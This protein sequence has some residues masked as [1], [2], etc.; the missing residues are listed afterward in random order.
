MGKIINL[1]R[2]RHFDIEQIPENLE[3][4]I[5]QDFREFT[6]G[7]AREYTF[8]DKLYYI[9]LMAEILHGEPGS[10]S[11]ANRLCIDMFKYN[12]EETNHFTDPDEFLDSGFLEACVD[13]GKKSQ[14]LYSHHFGRSMH[15]NEEI[16]R[17]MVRVITTVM[18]WD[19][20]KPQ[21]NDKYISREDLARWLKERS[22]EFDLEDV[23]PVGWTL[24]G[25]INELDQAPFKEIPN[26]AG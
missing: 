1:P 22:K 7:T 21:K 12:L 13:A 20:E 14:Q 26:D 19:P 9:D 17:V 18:L 11:S 16:M 6:A 10:A 4:L 5:G 24:L 2:G 3:E 23:S 8:E 15:E 25:L